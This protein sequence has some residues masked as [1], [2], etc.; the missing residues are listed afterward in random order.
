MPRIEGSLGGMET[1]T[2]KWEIV[3]FCCF[4]SIFCKPLWICV[5]ATKNLGSDYLWHHSISHRLKLANKISVA[6]LITKARVISCNFRPW[7]WLYPA[8]SS[9]LSGVYILQDQ[10]EIY[11]FVFLL[12]LGINAR[13]DCIWKLNTHNIAKV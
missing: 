3:L 5:E 11:V 1:I 8:S 6:L 13:V 4:L 9:W 2:L 12:F 7:R 10:L